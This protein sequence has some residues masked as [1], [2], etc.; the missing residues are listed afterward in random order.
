MVIRLKSLAFPAL[1]IGA[2]EICPLFPL[3]SAMASIAA[4][5]RFR[6]AKIRE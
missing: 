2:L 5:E 1:L 6:F 3:R 4:A